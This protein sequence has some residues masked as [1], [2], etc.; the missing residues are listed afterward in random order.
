MSAPLCGGDTVRVV[1]TGELGLV[2]GFYRRLP[3][4]V[5]VALSE[6]G[7]LSEFPFEALERAD[8]PAALIV[9]A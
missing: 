8:L 7:S 9:A 3:E 2:V 6:D 4:S 5:L 1:A